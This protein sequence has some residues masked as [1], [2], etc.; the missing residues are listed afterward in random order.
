MIESTEVA[1]GDEH[2]S[3][4]IPA[5]N[6]DRYLSDAIE[7]VLKQDYVGQL[8]II[9][10]DD[11]STDKT[12]QVAQAM[13]AK[14][15]NIA[16][17][18]QSNQGRVAVRNRLLLL[19]KT[20]LVAWLDGDD[21]AARTWIREQV[22][23]L[24]SHPDVLAVSG[25]G[26]AMTAR[27][28]AIGPMHHPLASQEI[29]EGHLAGRASNFFQSCALTKKSAV[30][31]AGAYREKYPAGEDY[32]L[33]LRL[34]EYGKLANVD[35]YHLFYRVHPTSAN[36]TIRGEQK[37]QGCLIVNEARM[38]RGLPVISSLEGEPVSNERDDWHRRI[39]WIN[40]ALR[41]GNPT[42]ALEML[43]TA[44]KR[45]PASL[46]LWLFALVAIAD[47]FLLWGNRT[48]QLLPGQSGRF[49]ELPWLSMY[50]FGRFLNRRRRRWCRQPKRIA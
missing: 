20:E 10:L 9:V 37:E 26:Y 33:W 25:Q 45:H 2:V 27:G 43:M 12:W 5:Y 40:I 13:A 21:V 17:Y 41:S 47:W 11:G 50:R 3:V 23:F 24:R 1:D 42:S 36:W 32:D 35:R 15:P 14:S 31:K 29:E 16:C 49:G 4:V 18:H 6:L 39:Y 30:E 22:E 28:L 19:A 48:T 46:L 38:R 44:L 7:S 8:S 34:G